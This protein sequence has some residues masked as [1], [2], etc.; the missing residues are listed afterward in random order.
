MAKK[1]V[2]AAKRCG[3][4]V[5]H[6]PRRSGRSPALPYPP[7]RRGRLYQDEEGF[8]KQKRRWCVSTSPLILISRGVGPAGVGVSSSLSISLF[9]RSTPSS[10]AA[11]SSSV[12]EISCFSLNRLPFDS[13][14]CACE[15]CF[16]M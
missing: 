3:P 12:R 7:S 15:D 6:L 16:G 4:S 1:A 5:Y 13:S 10:T 11:I 9:I 14:N 8:S 2:A